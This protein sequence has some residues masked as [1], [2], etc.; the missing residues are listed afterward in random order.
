MAPSRRNPKLGFLLFMAFPH[1]SATEF[2]VV[3]CV[4]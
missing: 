3:F 2:R 4:R 1:P